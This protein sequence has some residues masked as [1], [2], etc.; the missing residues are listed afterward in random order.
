MEAPRLGAGDGITS[1]CMVDKA[2]KGAE[3]MAEERRRDVIWEDAEWMAG[4][5]HRHRWCT[6]DIGIARHCRSNLNLMFS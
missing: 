1:N 6:G 2:N 5:L 4:G 3:K